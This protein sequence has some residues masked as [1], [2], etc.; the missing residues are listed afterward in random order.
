MYPAGH[1]G[2]KPVT[3]LINLP[4]TQVIVTTF[5]VGLGEILVGLGKILVGLGEILVGLGW[6]AELLTVGI[7][8]VAGVGEVIGVDD[9][10]CFS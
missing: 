2:F 9:C 7:G 1:F 3:F 5:L 8:V 4:L 10:D 6:I